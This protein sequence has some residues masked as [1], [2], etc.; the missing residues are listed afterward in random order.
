MSHSFGELSDPMFI[1]IVFVDYR[2]IKD[3]KFFF[4]SFSTLYSGLVQT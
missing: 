3:L 1:L 4:G 2:M